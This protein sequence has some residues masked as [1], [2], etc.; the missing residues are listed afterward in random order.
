MFLGSG[1]FFD[2]DFCCFNFDEWENAASG[3]VEES[4]NQ[5]QKGPAFKEYSLSELRKAT[6]GF[7]PDCIVSES[8]E[9][10]PN[11][12]YRGRLETNIF[13]AVKRFSKLSWPDAQQFLV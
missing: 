1:C 10:A 4:D 3:E 2:F 6:N 12:V 9:K 11:V 8:G 13:I 7:N 5:Q